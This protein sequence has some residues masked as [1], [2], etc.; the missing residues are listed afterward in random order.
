MNNL[1]IINDIKDV[2]TL[3]QQKVTDYLAKLREEFLKQPGDISTEDGRKQIASNA[4]A[5]ARAKTA[6]DKEGEKLKEDAAAKVKAVNAERKRI[7]EEM[8]KIQH[9]IRK[10]LTEWE[11]K[12]AKRVADHQSSLDIIINAPFFPDVDLHPD[13]IRSRILTLEN[14]NREWEEF[15]NR[16]EAAKNDSLA[17]LKMMLTKREKEISDAAELA[18]LREEEEKR[19][20]KEQEDKIAREAAEGARIEAERIAKAAADKAATEAEAERLRIVAEKESAERAAREAQE[21]ADKAEADRIAAI[22]KAE[23]DRLAAEKKAGED[24]HAH[25]KKINNEAAAAFSE[26]IGPPFADEGGR[27]IVAAI[28]QGKIPHVK[29]N[30]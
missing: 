14:S 7:W 6:I 15:S 2:I 24:N 1:A 22:T 8:E 12:D 16:A 21:R 4:Y 10:P 25:K 9:E 23:T 18:R 13:D 17:S 5:V 27:E 3:D 30:Y 20:Q 28:A 26:L 11:E 19:K 29:I